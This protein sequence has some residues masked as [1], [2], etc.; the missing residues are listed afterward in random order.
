MK[1]Y[2]FRPLRCAVAALMVLTLSACG[3][4]NDV[5]YEYKRNHGS[6][7]AFQ[8]PEGS[9]LGAVGPGSIFGSDIDP[10]AG[11]DT[12]VAVNAYLWR[13]ALDTISFMPIASA[14]PFGGTIL[15]DWYAP[16]GS[17]DERLKL[18]VAILDRQLTAN[19]IRVNA[20]RQTRTPMG[21]EDAPVD[22]DTGRKLEDAILTRARQLKAK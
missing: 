15:T 6:N 19:G 13:A 18:N 22:K 21:W 12:G 16:P 20:F 2:S 17:P 9:I 14:D 8:R 5:E 3:G 1:D 11:K 10:N 7:P 4:G